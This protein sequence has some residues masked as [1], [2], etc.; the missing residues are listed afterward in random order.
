MTAAPARLCRLHAAL[1]AQAKGLYACEAAAELLIAHASWLRRS[2]FLDAFVHTAPSPAGGTPTA[3]IHWPEAIGALDS[4]RLPCSSGEGRV[5]RIAASLAEGIPANLRDAITGLDTT[6]VE[7]VTRAVLHAGGVNATL[8]VTDDLAARRPPRGTGH[9]QEPPVNNPA[10]SNEATGA[11]VTLPAPA[12]GNITGVLHLAADVLAHLARDPQVDTDASAFLAE[13][14]GTPAR[15][16][17][18]IDVCRNQ[19]TCLHTQA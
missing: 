18:L 17:D 6:N 3:D 10:A 14:L 7:L 9:S 5:L 2:D 11:E 19:T 13:L 16:E 12:A 15:L 1:R 4:G 8:A